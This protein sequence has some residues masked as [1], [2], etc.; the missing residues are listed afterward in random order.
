ME[1]GR[2]VR[3]GKIADPKLSSEYNAYVT[4]DGIVERLSFELKARLVRLQAEVV[5]IDAQAAGARKILERFTQLDNAQ[6]SVDR[7]QEFTNDVARSGRQ[8]GV[9]LQSALNRITTLEY[10]LSKRQRST[11]GIFQRNEKTIQQD[12]T[13][14]KANRDDL[15]SR[16][17][18]TKAR[19][20]ESRARFE[21]AKVERDQLASDLQKFDRLEAQRAVADADKSR[22]PIV[23][24]LREI[25][26][27][28][29]ELRFSV[30]R[31]SKVLGLTCTKTYLA[32]REIG[33]VDVVIMDEASMVLLPMAWFA[34]GLA[35]ERVIVC[36]DFCQ[37]PPI[38]PT[39]QQAVFD[40]LGHDVFAA[41][42]LDN[43]LADRSRMIML[44]TQYRMDKAICG[45][46]S[47]PMYSGLLHTSS[48]TKIARLAKEMPPAPYDGTLTIVDTSDLWPF[49]S[50]NAFFSRFNLMHA[51]L[52]RNLVWHFQRRG[53]IQEQS[54]LAVCTPYAAQARLIGKLLD[55]EDFGRLV[56]VGTVHS[57]QGD[58]RDAILLELPESHGG[59]RMLGQFLQGIPPKHVGARLI[60]VAVSRAK[61]HL[62]VL[63]NLTHLDRLLPSASLLRGILYDIQRNGRVI[64]GADLLALRP[65]ESDLRGLIGRVPLDFDAETIGVFNQSTFD[66]AIEADISN[67]KESIVIFSGFVTP[68]RVAKLGDLLRLK[69]LEGVKIRCVTRPPKLNGTMDPARGKAALDA[70]ERINCVVDCRARIHEKIVLIDKEV[71]WHGS[72]NVL[73]HTHRTD[74]AMTRLVN[75][76]LAQA[77]AA[78]M[79]KRRVS[80]TKALQTVGDAENPRCERCGSRTVYNEGRYGPFFY[81]EE[82]CGWSVNLKAL[83]KKRHGRQ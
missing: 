27:K 67:A 55:G 51:L 47:E 18:E 42:G 4:V 8:L 15:I 70:L 20:V 61:N 72:L 1:K 13:E 59:A 36:G 7:H 73:S 80:T 69:A 3:L 79:S 58:E 21:N 28:I 6:R 14:T 45:L 17:D 9:D 10:E 44:D 19:Y 83:N 24:E 53:Y 29:A 63:A 65:I 57:F 49:E 16:I 64:P 30:L 32:V 22:V 76:G 78:N 12:I 41:A 62:L 31:E 77:I 54:D 71:V 75:S 68:S 25:E 2:I 23:G 82:E 66:P 34:A 33:Q 60:N 5:R 26:A 52:V 40:V 81:C 46:V 11:F 48:K 74:E 39:G 50:V 35:R 37:I 38:V 56:Q 43:P